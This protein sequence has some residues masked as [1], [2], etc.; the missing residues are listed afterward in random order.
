MLSP[1]A[2]MD[3]RK[4]KKALVAI[5]VVQEGFLEGIRQEF[6]HLRQKERQLM[7]TSEANEFAENT[8]Q[9]ELSK[10]KIEKEISELDQ[11]RKRFEVKI[12]EL[13]TE[14]EKLLAIIE[15][16]IRTILGANISVLAK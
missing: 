8:Q 12:S 11:S 15:E 13:Q 7:S 3:K 14:L 1:R 9:L 2:K 10:R 6:E 4:E 5:K 16:K